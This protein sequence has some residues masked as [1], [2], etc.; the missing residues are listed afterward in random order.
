MT[1]REQMERAGERRAGSG[2]TS[3]AVLAFLTL[4]ALWL[5]GC[6]LSHASSNSN[7][8]WLRQCDERT[9]CGSGLECVCGRCTQTCE[10]AAQCGADLPGASCE[11]TSSQPRADRCTGSAEQNGKSCALGCRGDQD[12][13]EVGAQLVCREGFCSASA[14]SSAERDGGAAGSGAPDAGSIRPDPNGRDSGPPD[15]ASVSRDAAVVSDAAVVVD[16]GP[17][18][19]P[20]G[21]IVATSAGC[22]ADDAFCIELPDGRYCTG[23]AAPECPQGALP[24]AR[25]APCPTGATCWQYSESLRCQSP[26]VIDFA[27]CTQRGGQVVL[28][29]GSG[30]LIRGGCPLARTALG[31]FAGPG[32]GGLCCQLTLEDCKPDDVVYNPT[33][34]SNPTSQ[35]HWTGQSCTAHGGCCKGPDCYKSATTE[36][37]C[38]QQHAGCSAVTEPCGGWTPNTCSADEYCAY[39][40]ECGQVDGSAICVP[41]PSSCAAHDLPV[42]GCDGNDYANLCEAAKA[43]T[44]V[45][46]R[47]GC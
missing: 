32:E 31:M 42:C 5:G 30:S 2:A 14:S 22:L 19:C 38:M 20:N 26:P 39:V 41:R 6:E 15:D 43:G 46:K 16:A 44:G 23:S 29:P 47:G 35:F 11:P 40:Q 1:Q 21:M 3:L 24:I 18:L 36:S 4:N 33:L 28:D 45:L 13:A 8:S 25:D 37:E 27:Q 7:T 17:N 34:C 10:S 9:A 12:C